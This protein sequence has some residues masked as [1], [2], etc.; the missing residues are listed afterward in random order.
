MISSTI[1][2]AIWLASSRAARLGFD[3]VQCSD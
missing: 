1:A 2:N 3:L